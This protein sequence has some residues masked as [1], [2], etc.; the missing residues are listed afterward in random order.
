[1]EESGTF[2]N[3]PRKLEKSS[4]PQLDPLNKLVDYVYSNI[5]YDICY[6]DFGLLV[7]FSLSAIL[8]GSRQGVGNSLSYGAM[9]NGC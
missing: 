5:K 1:M 7:L 4:F 6:S 9:L 2:W 8:D 3:K